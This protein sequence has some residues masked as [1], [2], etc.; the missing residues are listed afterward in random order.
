M[1]RHDDLLC[2]LCNGEENEFFLR[3]KHR[4]YY[5]CCTCQLIFV[6]RRYWLS[7]ENAKAIYDLHQN[8][9]EDQGYRKFLS[10]L[11]EP[12]L[13][14]IGENSEGLDFGC[15]PGPTLS[16]MFEEHGHRME[17]YDPF[18]FSDTSVLVKEYDFICTTEVVEHLHEP[19]REFDRLFSM[20][21][22]GCWLGIM[23]KLV[24]DKQAFSNW[25]YIRD[26][27]HICFFSRSTFEYLAQRFS[28]EVIFV[29]KDVILIRK[30]A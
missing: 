21:K 1:I 18:Y 12:L 23:T 8:D 3:D 15:G 27:T 11:T 16:L 2:P 19:N 24:L 22:S 28:A 17:V 5:Q 25:H 14:R 10:R 29:G 7:A 20:L 6:P 26:L 13:K 30:R 4:E 9:P